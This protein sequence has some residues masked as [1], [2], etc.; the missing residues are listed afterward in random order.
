ML[1]LLPLGFRSV[2]GLNNDLLRATDHN[3]WIPAVL[4]LQF[5]VK[6]KPKLC[7][8]RRSVGQSLLVL[9]PI[10][11]QTLDFRCCQN[12]AGFLISDALSDN[13]CRWS[14]PAQSFSAQSP[15]GFVT[16]FYYLRFDTP[17]HLTTNFP[18][19]SPRKRVAHSYPQALG[20]ISSPPTTRRTSAEVFV[21]AS[22]C[23]ESLTASANSPWLARTW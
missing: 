14:S 22:H 13:Y 4:W 15:T 23:Y 16:I 8:D 21:P 12:I 18:Y 17:S 3:H 2:H 11:G 7:H 10:L 5:K 9:S 20:S 1:A 6:V 19:L